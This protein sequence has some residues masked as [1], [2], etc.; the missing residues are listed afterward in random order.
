MQDPDI[1]YVIQA[2]Q[3]LRYA[4]L[5]VTQPDVFEMAVDIGHKRAAEV[6]DDT[7]LQPER[8]RDFEQKAALEAALRG[9][10]TY[11]LRHVDER[12]YYM[13]MGNRCKI[14]YTTNL[15]SRVATINPEELLGWEPGSRKLEQE[16]HKQFADLR[17]HGEWFRYEGPLV[18]H[19]EQ[20]RAS[21]RVA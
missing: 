3:G 17:T 9:S 2:V 1:L 7:E 20:L 4:G 8:E 11:G 15:R 13:R 12:V 16:R 21:R 5:D 6:D 14:G 19:V 10:P 18:E